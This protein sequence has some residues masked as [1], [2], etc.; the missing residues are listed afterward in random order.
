MPANGGISTSEK[1]WTKKPMRI[2]TWN[3]RTINIQIKEKKYG[4]I[5]HTLRKDKGGNKLQSAVVEPPRKK[6]SR[7]TS[8]IMA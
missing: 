3:V 4:W 7:R 6:T 1:R 8:K 2:G 5:G